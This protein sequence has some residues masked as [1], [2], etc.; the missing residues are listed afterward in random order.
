M[1]IGN[2]EKEIE[3]KIHFLTSM[4]FQIYKQLFGKKNKNLTGFIFL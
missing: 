2:S 3:L 4:Y 1:F